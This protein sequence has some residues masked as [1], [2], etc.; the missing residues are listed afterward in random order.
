MSEF[1]AP[2]D[3]LAVGGIPDETQQGNV[4]RIV[5]RLQSVI[6]LNYEYLPVFFQSTLLS[7]VQDHFE[8]DPDYHYDRNQPL[9]N[10][11]LITREWN[12][13]TL[14]Q[15]DN[16]PIISVGFLGSQT[17]HL[18]LRDTMSETSPGAFKARRVAGVE[19][20]STFQIAIV[21]HNPVRA[22]ILAQRL[23][24]RFVSTRL[25]LQRLYKLQNLGFPTLNGPQNVE[26][27]DDLFQVTMAIQ[28]MCLPRWT[29][30]QDPEYI[31][32]IA[33]LTQLNATDL[34]SEMILPDASRT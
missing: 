34:F 18:A 4:T 30:T 3:D 29:E 16:R 1:T 11:V 31:R 17:E 13:T 7:I 19:E 15:R 20:V 6:G 33:V 23:R 28:L 27:H 24:A 21:D 9:N 22:T 10:T 32:R 25:S 12:R 14:G 5:E 26:E 8:Q 2:Q